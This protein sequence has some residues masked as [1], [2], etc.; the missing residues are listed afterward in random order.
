MLIELN[1]ANDYND[2]ISKNKKLVVF[3]G[4]KN[5]PHCVNFYP[6][7]KDMSKEY[8][9]ITFLHVELTKIPCDGISSVPVFNF[10]Y[11]KKMIKEIVGSKYEEIDDT[12]K[13]LNN[14]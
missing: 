8:P 13:Y 7:F 2:I 11:N 12:L 4:S 6:N 9:N 3:F 10:F 5:C 1:N 14:F